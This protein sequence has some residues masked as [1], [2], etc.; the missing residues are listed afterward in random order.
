MKKTLLIL[1]AAF[2][3]AIVCAQVVVEADGKV[4]EEK[5]NSIDQRMVDLEAE[6]RAEVNRRIDNTLRHM[7][8]NEV[9]I[10]TN[11]VNGYEKKKANTAGDYDKERFIESKDKKAI[12]KYVEDSFNT[13]SYVPMSEPELVEVKPE[14]ES[15]E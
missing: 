12:K 14:T 15:E 9:S 7:N 10:M 2:F 4:Y 11:F 3:P 1:T 6:H 13:E 8:K 5:Y